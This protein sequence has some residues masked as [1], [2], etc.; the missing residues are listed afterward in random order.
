MGVPM[1]FGMTFLRSF[2]TVFDLDNRRVGFARS[3]LSPLPA[4]SKCI[5]FTYPIVRKIIWWISV[6][7]AL[8]SVFFA[9]Y[10]FF[11]PKDLRLLQSSSNGEDGG[12]QRTTES[13]RQPA[14]DQSRSAP[15]AYPAQTELANRNRQVSQA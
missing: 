11:V 8:F 9:I 2:Y 5:A 15:S 10:V 1:I 7:V 6:G 12:V 13:G 4:G 3:N 14:L